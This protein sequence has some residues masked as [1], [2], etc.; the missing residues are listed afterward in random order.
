VKINQIVIS[1]LIYV[2]LE[3]FFVI[4]LNFISGGQAEGGNLPGWGVV[5]FWIFTLTLWYA[6]YKYFTNQ[7]KKV[8]KP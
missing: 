8:S 6:P 7:N 3:F 5:V 4:L 2:V 1:I